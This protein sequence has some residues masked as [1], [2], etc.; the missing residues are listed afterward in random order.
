MFAIVTFPFQ[1]RNVR[2]ATVTV[3][4][5]DRNGRFAIV[6]FPLPDRNGRFEMLTFLFPDR[7]GR[8]VI[9]T[10]PF[11]D[12]NER[13]Q[14]INNTKLFDVVTWP[15]VSAAE[16]IIASFPDD[17]QWQEKFLGFRK[18]VPVPPLPI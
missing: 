6:T 3:P 4:F 16:W 10:F 8:F 13:L 12:R 14:K 15:S 17:S 7:N 1:D 5:Q 18:L 2:F 11:H 9:V